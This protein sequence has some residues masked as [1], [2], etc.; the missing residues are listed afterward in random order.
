M[1]II[2]F[3]IQTFCEQFDV[4]IVADSDLCEPLLV[5]IGSFELRSN[6]RIQ[7]FLKTVVIDDKPFVLGVYFAAGSARAF[8]LF[9]FFVRLTLQC[10]SSQ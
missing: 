3:P 8:G 7:W 6:S 2:K 10:K 4:F 5:D 9:Q 1:C